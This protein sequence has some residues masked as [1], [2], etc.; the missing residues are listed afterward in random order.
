MDQ[1]DKIGLFLK[2]F[3]DNFSCN[4]SP[5]IWSLFGLFLNASLFGENCCGYFLDTFWKKLGH[6]FLPTSGHSAF[7][8][9]GRCLP[10]AWWSCC[11]RQR[12]TLTTK[13]GRRVWTNCF[14]IIYENNTDQF[15]I[16]ILMQRW[17]EGG[18]CGLMVNLKFRPKN[19]INIWTTFSTLEEFYI[20]SIIKS[21]LRY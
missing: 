20:V 13:T 21:F 3:G 4:S 8:C 17:L 14:V 11:W 5:N 1:C 18:Q 16:S 7:D 9:V 12:V 19:Q 15:F 10:V 6:F 2:G